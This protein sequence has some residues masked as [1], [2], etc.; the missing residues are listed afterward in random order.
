[1]MH[2][3]ATGR[4]P[5]AQHTLAGLA[6]ARAEDQ[7]NAVGANLGSLC[8]KVA[9]SADSDCKSKVAEVR[10]FWV[11]EP[12]VSRMIAACREERERQL[13]I[14]ACEA[15]I[16]VARLQISWRASADLHAHIRG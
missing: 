16:G 1:M 12:T 7:L 8:Y 13:V 10:L 15:R 11:K 14:A 6:Q 2:A 3:Q 5:D 9:G 4:P